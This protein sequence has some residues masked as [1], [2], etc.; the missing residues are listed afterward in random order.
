MWTRFIFIKFIHGKII[1]KF[2]IIYL[3]VLIIEGK[4]HTYSF[5]FYSFLYEKLVRSL[6]A[7]NYWNIDYN[8]SWNI[9]DN[10]NFWNIIDNTIFKALWI[11]YFLRTIVMWMI[12]NLK[13]KVIDKAVV[14]LQILKSTGLSPLVTI[15][16][17]SWIISLC[18]NFQRMFLI[19]INH[20]PSLLLIIRDQIF[21]YKSDFQRNIYFPFLS[22]K[23]FF[24]LY[25]D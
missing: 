6:S 7:S 1:I 2:C 11:L 10:N 18:N 20:H 15:C 19:T 13:F 22:L 24:Y 5:L 23:L 17:F 21:I 4:I 14:R 9:I 3:I 25:V 12:I 8:S 16:E